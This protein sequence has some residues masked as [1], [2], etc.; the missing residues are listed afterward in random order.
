MEEEK[1]LYCPKCE[2][3]YTIDASKT[4]TQCPKCRGPLMAAGVE[5]EPSDEI[6]YVGER[7]STNNLHTNTSNK[8]KENTVALIAKILAAINVFAS[9][10]IAQDFYAPMNIMIIAIALVGSFFIFCIGE[11]VQLLDD[12][13][14][15]TSK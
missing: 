9:F 3:I 1:E 4:L 5:H 10:Y 15:N 6:E 14:S 11:V 13:K 8:E 2:K 7:E 12:I